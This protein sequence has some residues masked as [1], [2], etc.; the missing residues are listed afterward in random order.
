MNRDDAKDILL[1]YRPGTADA[2]EPQIAEALALV[3]Q[4]A[5]LATWFKEHSARQEAVRDRFREIPVPAGL[6]EQIIS[7]QRARE[8]VVV[9]KVN[10]AL[11]VAAVVLMAFVFA[12]LWFHH[13]AADNSLAVYQNRMVGVALRGYA[14][15]FMTNNSQEI[16]AYLNQNRAP[17]DYVLPAPL[18]KIAMA[19]CAVESWQGTKVSMICF[20]T[21]KPLPAGEQSD[22]WL[23]VADRNT[24]KNPPPAGAPQLAKVNELMTA[25]WTQGNRIYV[26][27][28]KGDEETL[29]QLL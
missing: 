6:K 11:A 4:D 19:G 12:G 27:G 5:G 8:R 15:D 26:L 13:P 17:A 1:L 9:W 3:R 21:G 29:R 23:F 10:A 20:R 22:L 24:V 28:T 18:Q 25:T 16:R 14:M 7:E 2:A